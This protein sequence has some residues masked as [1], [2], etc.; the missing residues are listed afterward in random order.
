[1]IHVLHL[2]LSY[3]CNMRCKH[4]FVHKRK[5]VLEIDDYFEII[6]ALCE[7]GLFVMYY[8]FGEPLLSDKFEKVASYAHKKGLV[9]ILMTNG[10][11]ID[12]EVIKVIKEKHFCKVC[13]SIDHV[14]PSK[15]DSN[16]NYQGAFDKAVNALKILKKSGIKTE[17]SVTVTDSNVDCLNDIYELGKVLNVDYISYLKERSDGKN[18]KLQKSDSYHY[19]FKKM[20]TTKENKIRVLFHDPDLLMNLKK[21][22]SEGEIDD[23]TYERFFEMNC[24][25]NKYTMSVEPSGEVLRCNLTHN[26]VGNVNE[27][28]IR[29]ILKDEVENNEC[30]SCCSAVS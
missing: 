6:D 14:I 15:H 8:T 4:C 26:V 12:D 24:C 1:M 11:L 28:S 25:H 10:S 22:R 21:M 19:F 9:Q 30:I 16:R 3:K 29:E 23:I 7:R 27:K 13:V 18:L 20:I 5:D 2:G 17:M